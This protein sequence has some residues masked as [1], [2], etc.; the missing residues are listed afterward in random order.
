VNAPAGDRAGD[1][2]GDSGLRSRAA[3][4]LDRRDQDVPSGEGA[5]SK[6]KRR[7]PEKLLPEEDLKKK[8]GLAPEGDVGIAGLSGASRVLQGWA[9][10]AIGT[11]RARCAVWL[12][13]LMT[14]TP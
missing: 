13:C 6:V 1:R 10:Y 2:A 4:Y 11:A 5:R 12:I 14:T 9:V 7:G 8:Q 3:A